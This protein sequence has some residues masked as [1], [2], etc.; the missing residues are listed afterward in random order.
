MAYGWIM[1]DLMQTTDNAIVAANFLAMNKYGYLKVLLLAE[2][3][4]P[5]KKANKKRGEK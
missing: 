3:H 5:G 4:I 2:K 1:N